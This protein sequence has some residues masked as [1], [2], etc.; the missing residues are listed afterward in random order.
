[1]DFMVAAV[2]VGLIVVAV[3]TNRRLA[4]SEVREILTRTS[5]Y[6]GLGPLLLIVA[7][8]NLQLWEA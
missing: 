4:G 8:L 1:M 3:F 7:L 2:V 6:L 5:G